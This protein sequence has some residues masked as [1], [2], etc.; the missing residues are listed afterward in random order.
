MLA[1]LIR[2]LG[3]CDP[4]EEALHEAFRSAVEIAEGCALCGGS[5]DTEALDLL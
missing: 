5:G 2:V 4:A 1:T 3:D